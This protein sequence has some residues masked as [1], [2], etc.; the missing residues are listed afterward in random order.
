MC[1]RVRE[2]GCALAPCRRQAYGGRWKEGFSFERYF[3]LA[4]PTPGYRDT[5]NDIKYLYCRL[6][7]KNN[8]VVR[9]HSQMF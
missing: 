8:Y 7:K 5:V 4:K 1:V 3:Q 2:K 9:L 6:A